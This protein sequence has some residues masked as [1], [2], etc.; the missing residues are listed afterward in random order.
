MPFR[1]IEKGLSA[2]EVIAAFSNSKMRSAVSWSESVG[3]TLPHFT[4]NFGGW[5]GRRRLVA[6][7]T[8]HE[9]TVKRLKQENLELEAAVVNSKS[10][11]VLKSPCAS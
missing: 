2:D 10:F 3:V 1:W 7:S 4:S 11:Q 8:G 6:N 9:E 5:F